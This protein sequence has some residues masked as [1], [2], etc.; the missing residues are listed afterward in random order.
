MM[1]KAQFWSYLSVGN[2]NG[3]WIDRTTRGWFL[4]VF[5]C[6]C[7]APIRLQYCGGPWKWRDPKG[8]RGKLKGQ[9][10]MEFLWR[11]CFPPN[12]LGVWGSTVPP[13]DRRLCIGSVEASG[14]L[15]LRQ[16][17]FL[18]SSDIAAIF[19]W[20]S[21]FETSWPAPMKWGYGPMRLYKCT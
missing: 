17:S 12:Q 6:P 1:Y 2:E 7:K 4:H 20:L 21:L 19:C 16:L 5:F 13:R 10:G 15:S 18:L 8:W 14:S 3:L 11:G 9:I